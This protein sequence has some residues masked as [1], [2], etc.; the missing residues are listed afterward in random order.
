MRPS[1]RAA[2]GSN[3]QQP[4][5]TPRRTAP[6]QTLHILTL[7]RPKAWRTTAVKWFEGGQLAR[8]HDK[9]K[10][11]WSEQSARVARAVT[12]RNSPRCRSSSP[13]W[14]N[15]WRRTRPRS[16]ARAPPKSKWCPRKSPKS[17]RKSLHSVRPAKPPAPRPRVPRP[18][19]PPTAQ[20][21]I[22]RRAA[23]AQRAAAR[24]PLHPARR[25]RAARRW[26]LIWT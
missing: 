24:Q 1:T 21:P 15:S 7:C 19:R 12:P 2:I 18:I 17:K 5:N 22:A 14:K 23:A 20:R 4:A 25:S 26:E 6:E 16:P 8:R 9:E 11:S 3:T 10:A 13:R